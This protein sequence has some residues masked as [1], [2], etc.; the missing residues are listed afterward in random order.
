MDME[1]IIRMFI[2][3]VLT[4]IT[5]GVLV[6]LAGFISSFISEECNKKVRD[7]LDIEED[8]ENDEK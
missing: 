1:F 6:Y 4:L 8:E 3:L 7:F 2:N 5:M